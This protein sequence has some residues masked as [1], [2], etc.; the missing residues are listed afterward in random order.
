MATKC[1][2]CGI[3]T[4]SELAKEYN[5]SYGISILKRSKNRLLVSN[6]RHIICAE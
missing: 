4:V 2:E 6:Q 1:H 5:P 3:T